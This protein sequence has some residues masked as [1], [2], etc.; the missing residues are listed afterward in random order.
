MSGGGNGTVGGGG[1]GELVGRREGRLGGRG[2]GK[3]KGLKRM[4]RGGLTSE[5][6]WKAVSLVERVIDMLCGC[7]VGGVWW[8]VVEG[9]WAGWGI[10]ITRRK[11]RGVVDRYRRIGYTMSCQ[12][13][14]FRRCWRRV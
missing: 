10:R 7:V 9:R 2:G 6:A 11:G 14:A 3:R 1:V 4:G 5:R 13:F 12:Y 8:R